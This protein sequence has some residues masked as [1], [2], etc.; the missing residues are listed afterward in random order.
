MLL[1]H[2]EVVWGIK[3]KR[4]K[5]NT[6]KAE[7]DAFG[8]GCQEEKRCIQSCLSRCIF[9]PGGG[10]SVSS[11][12]GPKLRPPIYQSTTTLLFHA[13]T[14]PSTE[15][16]DACSHA[17]AQYYEETGRCLLRSDPLS[18][19]FGQSVFLNRTVHF[20]TVYFT[21][22]YGSRGGLEN[23]KL[24]NNF[25]HCLAINTFKRQ[26]IMCSSSSSKHRVLRES[27]ST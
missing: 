10:P 25:I 2:I 13:P 7:R 20:Y 4:K 22:C 5:Q 24:L 12:E 21:L 18:A 16:C 26:F 6:T 23:E 15:R 1:I 8:R 14:S 17:N 19:L 3:K 9:L 11:V 27:S